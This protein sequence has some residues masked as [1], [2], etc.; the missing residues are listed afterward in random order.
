MASSIAPPQESS[1]KIQELCL[2]FILFANAR[3]QNFSEP[4]ES[5]SYILCLVFQVM[6][7]C[8]DQVDS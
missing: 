6:L 7:H 2:K 8:I 5:S 1:Y 3:L 4:E